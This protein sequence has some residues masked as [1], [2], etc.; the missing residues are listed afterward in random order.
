MRWSEIG[1]SAGE[2]DPRLQFTLETVNCV[3]ACALGP[4]VVVDGEHHGQMNATKAL[5]VVER[6]RAQDEASG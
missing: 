2:T 4:V 3:G 5:R 1:L 6:L